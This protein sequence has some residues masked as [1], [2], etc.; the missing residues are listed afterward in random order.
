MLKYLPVRLVVCAAW[1]LLAAAGLFGMAS[2][3]HAAG[4]TGQTPRQ[5]PAETGIALDGAHATLLM[6]AH[7]KCPCTRASIEELNRLLAKCS[8]EVTPHILFFAPESAPADW[9]LSDLWQSAEEIPGLIVESDPQGKKAER[10]GAETSG[11]VV[12]YN[13]HGELLFQGGITAGR[14]H[15]GENSGE[16]ALLSLLSAKT[17]AMTQTPV[18][19]CSLLNPERAFRPRTIVCTKP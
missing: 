10:F 1:L 17:P 15:A 13:S 12:L 5:W 4:G 6:F 11:Y 2:Y 16:T 8:G 9:A 3:D 18:F 19:G 7:P 14:G